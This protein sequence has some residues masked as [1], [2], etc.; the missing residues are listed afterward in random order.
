MQF[1]RARL[2]EV[3]DKKLTDQT[4]TPNDYEVHMA[5]NKMY[6]IDN[7]STSG[8]WYFKREDKTKKKKVTIRPLKC[9]QISHVI[10]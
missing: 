3:N 9:H 6:D 4:R 10:Y 5:P 2:S 8:K 1:K 7:E